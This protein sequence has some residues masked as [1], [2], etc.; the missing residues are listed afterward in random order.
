M[1]G[2]PSPLNKAAHSIF[3]LARYLYKVHISRL[4]TATARDSHTLL[5]SFVLFQIRQA[6]YVC[7]PESHY[8]DLKDSHRAKPTFCCNLQF[9]RTIKYFPNQR[10]RKDT[11]PKLNV[12]KLKLIHT[13]CVCKINSSMLLVLLLVTPVDAKF[14][15]AQKT[16]NPAQWQNNI[17][18][19]QYIYIDR[20]IN[21]GHWNGNTQT[22]P[23]LPR[24]QTWLTQ[25]LAFRPTKTR[26][27][28]FLLVEEFQGRSLHLSLSLCHWTHHR[29]D[30]EQP[31]CS[32]PRTYSSP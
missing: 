21:C 26:R 17:L 9:L 10:H 6:Y 3:Q 19:I 30:T 22:I 11:L 29:L 32:M 13:F 27:I 24:K 12:L 8:S 31:L 5:F 4:Q 2:T 15:A 14:Q 20:S 25:R 23:V 28:T 1:L 16:Q 18:Y 7:T